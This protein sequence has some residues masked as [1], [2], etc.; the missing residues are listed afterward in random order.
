MKI[1]TS[2]PIFY[3]HRLVSSD[4]K[5]FTIEREGVVSTHPLVHLLHYRILSPYQYLRDC[6]IYSLK[7]YEFQLL[8][9]LLS[10]TRSKYAFF[11]S[12]SGEEFLLT[13][14][15]KIYCGSVK[16][17]KPFRENYETVK[18]FINSFPSSLLPSLHKEIN[19]QEL[20]D[21]SVELGI[22]SISLTHLQ[23]VDDFTATVT[24]TTEYPSTSFPNETLYSFCS[25]VDATC[26]LSLEERIWKMI[27]NKS[28]QL[29]LPTITVIINNINLPI[30]K[31]QSLEEVTEE[32]RKQEEEKR[33]EIESTLLSSIYRI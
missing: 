21:A 31:C 20:F 27:K 12:S 18:A 23:K 16:K 33:K 22:H 25:H 10:P 32:I 15:G 6:I 14:K 7:S 3:Y 4:E 13:E 26:Y 9:F 19:L 17:Y 5:T 2:L 29:H 24:K 30:F 8:Y 11:L 28:K 1:D